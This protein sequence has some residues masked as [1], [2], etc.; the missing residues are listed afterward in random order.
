MSQNTV[1]SHSTV[2]TPRWAAPVA[3]ALS[4]AFLL[5]LFLLHFL[6]PE[7]DPSW[8]MISEYEIGQFGWMMRLAFFCW[9]GSVLALQL[10]LHPYLRTWGGKMGRWWLVLIGVALFGAGIFVTD[11]IT[12]IT[13]SVTNR[14]HTLAGAIVIFTFPISASLVARSLPRNPEWHDSRRW[15]LW[16]TLLVWFGLVA[17]VGTLTISVLTNPLAGRSGPEVLQGWPNRLMVVVYN[18][19][20]IV[21]ALRARRIR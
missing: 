10:V 11:P 17:Y 15:L 3:V 16:T 13:T 14:M 4:A 6:E 12:N 5:L 18:V 19:W 8:R 21:V 7:L 2:S 20:L 9:G 1:V